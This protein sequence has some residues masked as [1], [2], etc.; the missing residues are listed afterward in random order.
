VNCQ[1]CK[2]KIKE[3][4]I[5]Y[6]YTVRRDDIEGFGVVHD[7]SFTICNSCRN[8]N[9]HLF[10]TIDLVGVELKKGDCSNK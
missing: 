8:E 1:I 10:P 9:I 7:G 4:E 5:Y 3:E 6:S 2:N